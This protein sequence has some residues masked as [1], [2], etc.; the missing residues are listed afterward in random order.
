MSASTSSP[1]FDV[2]II[3]AGFAG[4]ATAWALARQAPTLRVALLERDPALGAY[5]SGR[6]AGMGRQL[7]EDDETTA[8]T[9][10]GARALREHGA[11]RFWHERGGLLTFDEAEHAASY[12]ARAAAH[13]L[14]C[15]A[16]GRAELEDLGLLA[17]HGLW[18]PSDG[19]I[20]VSEFLAFLVTR[21]QD[22]GA[23]L[24][25]GAEVSALT[26]SPHGAS[27]DT[28]RGALTCRAVVEATGAWAGALTGRAFTPLRRHVHVL[29]AA[30]SRTRAS[31]G[32]E[33]R[34]A[35]DGPFVWHIGEREVYLRPRADGSW[36]SSPCDERPGAPGD[37]TI[38]AEAVPELAARLGALAPAWAGAA[39]QQA[40]SCQRTF[41]AGRRMVI[42]RDPTHPQLVWA[43]ALGGHG[44]T[45]A[46]AVGEAT[47]ALVRE[48]L[49]DYRGVSGTR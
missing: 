19:L 47:A 4:A 9:L 21:A 33:P 23:A 44:A 7:A 32:A 38:D 35:Q 15:R 13:R 49:A 37:Q 1:D 48:A 40:W 22:G 11:G 12:R 3:G 24:W 16:L 29:A 36:L 26:A 20:D 25:L 8:L 41:A 28:S 17:A 27:L 45:A 30:P 34:L 46:C 39:P 10:A 42:E 6:S 5:A 2:V 43:A 31:T 14:P 18:V